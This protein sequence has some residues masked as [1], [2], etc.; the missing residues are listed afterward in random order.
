MSLRSP[1]MVASLLFVALCSSLSSGC[2]TTEAA[3]PTTH[4][5]Q[6]DLEESAGPAWQKALLDVASAGSTEIPR[7]EGMFAFDHIVFRADHAPAESEMMWLVV[8][9]TLDW[10]SR[11]EGADTSVAHGY[12]ALM[13]ELE[14]GAPGASDPL[15]VEIVFL[16]SEHRQGGA[17][18]EALAM[19]LWRRVDQR[20]P[21][22]TIMMRRSEGGSRSPFEEVLVWSH[23]DLR[24]GEGSALIAMQCLNIHQGTQGLET[25]K[26]DCPTQGVGE[27][28]AAITS[29]QTALDGIIWSSLSGTNYVETTLRDRQIEGDAWEETL[30][31][32]LLPS[33]GLPRREREIEEVSGATAFPPRVDI[34]E[35]F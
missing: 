12:S 21:T 19:R 28:A 18:R 35:I 5:E 27:H 8:H 2:K 25:L 13:A 4:K 23:P 14:P 9:S 20:I 29:I 3:Q 33:L 10:L 22:L 32:G 16:T 24:G 15:K 11:R 1:S 31:P 17:V 34:D 6:L 30:H 26:A 7:H